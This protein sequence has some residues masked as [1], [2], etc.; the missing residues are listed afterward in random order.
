MQKLIF[1]QWYICFF[2]I[3]VIYYSLQQQGSTTNLSVSTCHF[4]LMCQHNSFLG[5]PYHETTNTVAAV[6]GFC[7]GVQSHAVCSTTKL[8]SQAETDNS[9]QLVLLV[10]LVA[11]SIA[12]NSS[13]HQVGFNVHLLP[14]GG[15]SAILFSMNHPQD[16]TPQTG[17]YTI[18]CYR[19]ASTAAPCTL[20]ATARVCL[21]TYI[22]ALRIV[23]FFFLTA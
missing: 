12:S 11:K 8:S 9:F 1:L 2:I 10:A 16:C 19:L 13:V 15:Q 7:P 18:N 5:A 17:V 21:T 4:I 23:C 20:Q 14:M 3:L 22:F 6:R